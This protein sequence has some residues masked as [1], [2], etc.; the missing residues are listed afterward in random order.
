[1]H[2]S[3]LKK[4]CEINGINTKGLSGIDAYMKALQEHNIKID[5]HT[6]TEETPSLIIDNNEINKTLGTLNISMEA[7]RFDKLRSELNSLKIQVRIP[8]RG[9]IERQ[10]NHGTYT[11][12]IDPH[13]KTIH[14]LGGSL[15][16]IC[17]TLQTSDAQIIQRGALYLN[18][19]TA[20]GKDL[21]IAHMN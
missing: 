11:Y 2:W 1:M 20:Q 17:Q 6:K 4:L 15:G 19:N 12:T 16:P 9:I 18:A 21:M 3:Q 14:F 10:F 5:T 8:G 13:E 7:I